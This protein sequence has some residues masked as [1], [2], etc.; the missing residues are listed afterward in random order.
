M[1][2]GACWAQQALS[3]RHQPDFTATLSTNTTDGSG[4]S[5]GGTGRDDALDDEELVQVNAFD[6]QG[7]FARFGAPQAQPQRRGEHA[8]FDLGMRRISTNEDMSYLCERT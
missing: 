1:Q 7:Y 6:D 8:G 3:R 4:G 5:G 2:S